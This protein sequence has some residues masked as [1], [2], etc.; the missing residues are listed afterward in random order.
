MDG[1]IK[2]LFGGYQ[3]RHVLVGAFATLLLLCLAFTSWLLVTRAERIVHGVVTEVAERVTYETRLE[4]ERFLDT[5]DL[6]NRHVVNALRRARVRGDDVDSLHHLFWDAPRDDDHAVSAIYFGNRYG[7]FAGLDAVSGSWPPSAWRYTISSANTG[8]RLVFI[9][10]DEAGIISSMPT[11]SSAYDPRE[12][13]WYRAAA[14]APDGESVWTDVYPNFDNDTLT[15][16]R[17]R[18]LRD[19]AGVLL[20]VAGVDLFL[21]HL[22]D[23]VDRLEVGRSGEVFLVEADGTLIAS[24][25]GLPLGTEEEPRPDIDS[26]AE[27]YTRGASRYVKERFGGFASIGGERKEHIVLDGEEGYL[28]LVPIASDPG[29]DWTLGVFVP[30]SDYVG[31]VPAQLARV[32][33]LLLLGLLLTLFVFSVFAELVVKPLRQL[34]NGAARIAVGEFD[35]P[36]DTDCRNEVGDLAR[37]IDDMRVRLRELFE[38]LTEEK[39]RAEVTLESITDGVVTIDDE[40]EVYYMNPVA[41]RFVGR[42][43]ERARGHGVEEIFRARDERTGAPLT[44][45]EVLRH[46]G[47]SREIGRSMVVTSETGDTHLVHCSVSPVIDAGGRRHGAVLNFSDLSEELRLRSELVHQATHDPL[48]D[49]VNR[50]EFERRTG[51]AIENAR[52]RGGLHVLCYVDLDRFKIVNDSAGHDAGDE[53]L[54]QLS[55]LLDRSVRG[56]DSV[57]R[58]GG[59]EFGVLLE[60]CTLEQASR[61]I[62][63]LRERVESF[64]FFW[65]GR[66]YRVGISAGLVQIDADSGSVANVMRD[67]DSACYIAKE[68]GRNRVHAHRDGDE[69]LERL[70]GDRSWVE[71]IESALEHDRFV[72]HAQ[73]IEPTRPGPT[74][75]RHVEILLRMVGEEG[76]TLSP[77]E[78]LPAAERYGL[79]ARLDRWVLSNAFAWT[80]S[81]EARGEAPEVCSINLSGQSLGDATMLGFIVDE[82]RGSG[83]SP[84]RLCFEVT[85]TATIAN[86]TSAL[87]L[88]H[89]L[90]EL[91]CTFAIDDFGSGLSSFAYLKTLPVDYLKIDGMFVREMLK[92]PLD[93]AMVRSINEIGQT[94]GMRTIAEYV[95]DES[96]RRALADLGV[97]YV[98][99]YGIG[100]PVPLDALELSD[101]A[102]IRH[103][104]G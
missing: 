58:I 50:R 95:E 49:L 74:P 42:T 62:E 72:L 46:V 64:R 39:L 9:D 100:R 66:S 79:G 43:L 56:G 60:N 83:A 69:Q 31:S 82:I 51:G 97:D 76:E 102:P 22:Q 47:D 28:T 34:R 68:G 99:G 14:S 91:G 54:R 27:R 63:S 4:I 86:L 67:A 33:P 2:R 40:G 85:E 11:F 32:L 20:G 92:Q 94:M 26:T 23:F 17:A 44:R 19:S 78:F 84:E 88:I 8:G 45:E 65:A 30:E 53:L 3:S 90:R 77:G 18:A 37:A 24:H 87:S 71:R 89:T 70:R 6:I 16:T 41:E 59:D 25:A 81:L 101:I 15:I 10:T 55:R 13:P 61:L 57:G 29:L 52:R 80:A 104:G 35:V 48:T 36:I 103:A 1:L 93:L 5:P 96:T 12:R 75:Y 98:Q 38:D 73:P 21:D 7:S